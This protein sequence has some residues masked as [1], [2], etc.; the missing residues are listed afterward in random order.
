MGCS[1]QRGLH[2]EEADICMSGEFLVMKG[3]TDALGLGRLYLDPLAAR[4]IE[5][6][7]APCEA[8]LIVGYFWHVR[9][10]QMTWIKET[11]LCDKDRFGGSGIQLSGFI[12]GEAIWENDCC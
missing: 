5:I 7:R 4:E 2:L 6:L 9:M 8:F 1:D 11:C 3:Q 10:H 12:S